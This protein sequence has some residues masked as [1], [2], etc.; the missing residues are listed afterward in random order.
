LWKSNKR[1]RVA[2]D[3]DRKPACY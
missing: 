2:S 3:Q 1:L